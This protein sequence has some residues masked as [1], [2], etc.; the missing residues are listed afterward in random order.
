M[1][2]RFKKVSRALALPV[3]GVFAGQFMVGSAV[4]QTPPPRPLE[5]GKRAVLFVPFQ[6]SEHVPEGVPPRIEE[7]LRALVEIDPSLR[8]V[9]LPPETWKAPEEVVAP[10]PDAEPLR[11]NPAIERARAQAGLGREAVQ[12]R[13]YEQG[14]LKLMAAEKLYRAHLAELEDFEQYVD[15]LVWIAA[16]LVLGGFRE[17][18]GPA[19]RNLVTLRPDIVLPATDFDKRFSDAV[20]AAKGRLARGGTLSIQVND[21][22][23]SVYV[24][25]RLVGQGSQTVGDLVQGRHFVRVTVPGMKPQGRFVTV[26]KGTA[27]ASFQFKP[28]K[29]REVARRPARPLTEYARTGEFDAAFVQDAREAVQKVSC[30]FAALGYVARSDTAF[31]IGLFLFEAGGGR[32]AAIEP[33]VVDTDLTNLQVALL[34]LESRLAKAVERFPEDRIV[35]TRPP[36]YA[37]APTQRPVVAPAPPVVAAPV[38]AP[39]TKPATPTPAPTPVAT[40]PSGAFED[41]PPDFPMEGLPGREPSKAWYEKWWV[42]TAIGGA[43]AVALGVGLGVGLGKGRGGGQ[44]TFGA[45][46]SW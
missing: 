37:I 29:P 12:K 18:A 35:R 27:T 43:A 36:I 22:G 17:E 13:R 24:D 25:G 15:V 45:K 34:E 5:A 32:L 28:A 19:V 39:P 46:V 16:G 8:L 10:A 7:Y 20:E 2:V 21:D 40:T 3:L 33:A 4:A 6:R 30:E 42:W 1:L 38:P 31:H 14:L 9:T 41:I 26:G 23:A 11:T 44:D